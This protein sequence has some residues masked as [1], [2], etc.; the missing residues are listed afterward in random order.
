MVQEVEHN[1]AGLEWALSGADMTQINEVLSRYGVDT[2][3][4]III[5][6]EE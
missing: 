5:D 6:P 3:P 1:V 4:D 2:Y